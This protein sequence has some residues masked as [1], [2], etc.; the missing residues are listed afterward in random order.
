M[1]QNDDVVDALFKLD[2]PSKAEALFAKQVEEWKSLRAK[3]LI[4]KD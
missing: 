2:D 1:M 3:Y 4:Y